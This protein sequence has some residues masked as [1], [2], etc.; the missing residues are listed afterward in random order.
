MNKKKKITLLIIS[1]L[2]VALLIPTETKKKVFRLLPN[3]IENSLKKKVKSLFFSFPLNMQYV[4]KILFHDP[5][6]WKHKGYPSSIEIFNND[7]NVKFLPET[8]TLKLKFIKKYINIDSKIKDEKKTKNPYSGSNIGRVRAID[9]Y[10]KDTLIVPIGKNQFA[11]HKI[12]LEIINSDKTLLFKEIKSN[13]KGSNI[14]DSHISSETIFISHVNKKNNCS[15]MNV[16]SSNINLK[17]MNFQTLM[18]SEECSK[19]NVYGGR[20]K[21]FNH[22]NKEGILLTTS[23]VK[24]NEPTNNAQYDD[25]IFGKILFI[26]TIS[27]KIINYSKGHRNPQGL[28]VDNDLI[29]STEHGPQGGDEINKISFENNYGWPLASYGTRYNKKR[30]NEN[31]IEANKELKFYNSHEENSFIEPI[32]S[33]LP[34]IGISEMIKIPNSFSKK[35]KDNFLISSLNDRSLYRVKFSKDFNKILYME[36]IYVG[37]RIRDIK[38]DAKNNMFIL[39]FHDPYSTELGFLINEN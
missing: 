33:F 36:K 17:K 28:Y 11:Y 19:Q 27:K 25:S 24:M 34:S 13:F 31:N 32:Y 20:I 9:I 1:F 21:N 5:S 6:S 38:F 16:S 8:Q 10:N 15:Y 22:K 30:N 23:E 12:D 3:Q 29:L 18:A 14:L 26:D 37:S 39:L 2:L 4:V 35:W 7:Y